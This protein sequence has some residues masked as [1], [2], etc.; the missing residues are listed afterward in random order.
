MDKEVIRIIGKALDGTMLSKR[1][2]IALLSVPN[3]SGEAFAI[4]QAGREFTSLLCSGK[5]EIHGHIGLDAAP[6]PN[7]CKFC[8]FAVSSKIFH[9]NFKL[10]K[11]DVLRE[12]R[13]FEDA[14]INAL[15]LVTTERY[16]KNDFLEMASAVIHELNTPLPV[17]AN[18]PDFDEDYAHELVSI[19]ITGVYHVVRLGEGT[20]TRCTV[21]QRMRT[22]DA[23]RSAGLALGNCIEP[24][25]P[26]HAPQEIA[27][28]ILLA[29][30]TGVLF[31]GAMRRNTI[32]GTVFEQYGNISYG[33]LAT[34]TAAISLAT[35]PDIKG[36][37]THEPSQLCAQAGGNIIWAER[38]SSPRD[39]TAETTRGLT[40]ADCRAIYRETDWDILEGPSKIYPAATQ[41]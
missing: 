23:A 29:R 34:L 7:D 27:D 15:Y 12:T 18:I 19:G 5:A 4:Q 6:C 36:N 17:I 11:E 41:A 28:K 24:I 22:I 20:V 10:S 21:E 16:G 40:V 30:E 25:G 38:G 3:L 8:S 9:D 14:G 39:V 33:R 26:E 2:I 1:E 32:P 35:G 13:A 31:S 37:C